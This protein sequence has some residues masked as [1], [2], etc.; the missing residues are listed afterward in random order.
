MSRN[1]SVARG[2]AWRSI[3]NLLTNPAFLV[4]SLLFP[5]FF[6]VAFAGGLSRVADV[7]GFDFHDG[8]TAFQFVF[9]LFQASAF[10]GV[11][12]G[13]G[14]AR[15][16]ES[17]FGRRLMLAAP[18]RE[19]ILLGYAV[20]AIGRAL[21]TIAYIACLAFLIAGMSVSGSVGDLGGLLLLALLTN[22]A[23]SM[24][25]AGIAL[26]FRSL[27]ASP[28]MQLPVFLVLFLAPVYLPL[29]LLNGWI[30][31]VATF[32]PA[33]ALLEAG[34]GLISGTHD[35]TLLAFAAAATLVLLLT[36]WGLRGMRSAERAG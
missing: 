21:I 24:W 25:A 22:I 32:N 8:Y 30:H 33:T 35:H 29:S 6:F 36:A 16:W 20:A 11:F 13:F 15:D 10:G 9:V 1:I 3:H 19:A 27:Q 2:I 12:T 5:T 28:L 18:R 17:G 31:G 14:I 23:A 7:P 4:P 26:R 34:R